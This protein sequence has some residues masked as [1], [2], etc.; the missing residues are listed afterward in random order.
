MLIRANILAD[1]HV[2]SFLFFFFLCS[3]SNAR[4]SPVEVTTDQKSLAV[5]SVQFV[6]VQ[7]PAPRRKGWSTNFNLVRI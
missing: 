3:L 6:R 1:N 2:F 7:F 4:V 5:T